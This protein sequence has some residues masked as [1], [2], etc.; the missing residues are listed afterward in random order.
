VLQE[1]GAGDIPQVLVYNKIDRI[2]DARPRHD[3][4]NGGRERL[5]LS[6]HDGQGLDLLE[7]A[8]AQRLSLVRVHGALD[9]P[10]AHAER[11]R[12][13]LHGLGAVRAE[14]YDEHGWHLQVDL[15]LADARRLA[16]QP[17]GG[18]LEA[19]LPEESAEEWMA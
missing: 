12:A 15:S 1:I 11:L 10:L 17:G 14:T 18:P 7:S 5:W 6:A 2:E 9:L 19:L 3:Q 13:R 8:L 4:P 16:T